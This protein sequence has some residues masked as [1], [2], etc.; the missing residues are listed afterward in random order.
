M[1]E[2]DRYDEV[3]YTRPLRPVD[4]S[5]HDWGLGTEKDVKGKRSEITLRQLVVDR[6]SARGLPRPVVIEA[7]RTALKLREK[8]RGRLEDVA[9]ASVIIVMKVYG[10]PVI[11]NREWGRK[12]SEYERVLGVRPRDY[13]MKLV[14]YVV[15][16][17]NLPPTTTYYASLLARP[18]PRHQRMAVTC[19]YIVANLFSQ[20][21]FPRSH[22]SA[23]LGVT[24]STVTRTTAEILEFHGP[25]VYVSLTGGEVIYKYDTHNPRGILPMS[26]FNAYVVTEKTG[27]QIKNQVV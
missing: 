17:F 18:L 15:D 11:L 2:D 13:V 6:A 3:D 12:V 16:H 4:P 14:P 10:Y 25:L 7:V 1:Q 9:E 8:A 5:R 21:V 24:E 27:I 23:L 19:V 22:V 26:M 20:N